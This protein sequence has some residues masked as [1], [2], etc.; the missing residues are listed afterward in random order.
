M[1]T[2]TATDTS[3]EQEVI[4]EKGPVLVDFWAPWCGPCKMLGPI[5][6]ELANEKEGQLKVVK[7]DV[8]QNTNIAT[9]YN[10]RT[11]PTM[12]L[13]KDG[14]PVDTKIGMLPK[15]KLIEWVDSTT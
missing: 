12:I 4:Q 15:N 11:I 10:V 3:F 2:K 5:L 14:A 8:D 13:F 7:V 9:T 1:S 6:D